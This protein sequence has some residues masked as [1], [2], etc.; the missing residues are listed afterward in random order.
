MIEIS[1]A[2]V[3]VGIMAWDIA[4]RAVAAKP[5]PA[6][7]RI[8]QIEANQQELA[9]DMLALRDELAK[10]DKVAENLA[11]E[12]L[13]RFNELQAQLPKLEKDLMQKVG[14]TLASLPAKGYNR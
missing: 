12:W 13:Q 4:R 7:A 5:A 10:T 2:L 14:G 8:T 3:L 11:N 1:V 6:S 9:V